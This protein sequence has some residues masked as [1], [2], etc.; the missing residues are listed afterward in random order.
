MIR[1]SIFSKTGNVLETDS[2]RF[3]NDRVWGLPENVDCESSLHYFLVRMKKTSR[4]VLAGGIGMWMLIALGVNHR[5]GGEDVISTLFSYDVD[6]HPTRSPG[7]PNNTRVVVV[8]AD[9]V[10]R[11][12]WKWCVPRSK[13]C[14]VSAISRRSRRTHPF[15]PRFFFGGGAKCSLQPPDKYDGTGAGIRGT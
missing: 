10:S 7:E 13:R 9:S 1:L 5:L 2:K 11:L 4:A 15:C 8:V 3:D 14:V 12:Q 6:R